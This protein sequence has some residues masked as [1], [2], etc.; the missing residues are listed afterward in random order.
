MQS[1]ES[2]SFPHWQGQVTDS[3]SSAQVEGNSPVH[4]SPLHPQS[5]LNA[6]SWKQ[7]RGGSGITAGYSTAHSFPA[8]L[9]LPNMQSSQ[10]IE[11]SR[12]NP[13]GSL[14]LPDPGDW[15]PNYR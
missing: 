6:S 4:G 5:N 7:Q 15:D 12:D 8:S 10:P 13:E 14:S 11:N 1:Q 9:T 3:T 2:S